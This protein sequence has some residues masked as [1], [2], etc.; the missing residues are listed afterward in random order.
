[1]STAAFA[2]AADE[3]DDDDDVVCDDDAD[4]CAVS[5]AHPQN[6]GVAYKRQILRKYWY[7]RKQVV[8]LCDRV[9]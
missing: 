7:K 9:I 6:S 2:A 5:A 4:D 8:C 1:M 3:D